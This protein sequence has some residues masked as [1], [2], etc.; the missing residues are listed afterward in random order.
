MRDWYPPG[1]H[2]TTDTNPAGEADLVRRLQAG[3]DDAYEELVRAYAGRL[4]GAVRRYLP[5]EDDARDAVQEAFLSAFKAIDRFEGGSRL[6]TWLY[7]IA[8]NAAL[9]Q[10]RRRSSR[11]SLHREKSTF[12]PTT[13]ANG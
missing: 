4:L 2:A 5:A 8:I 9:M 6:Y 1:M 7:R 12:R 3:D 11:R 10:I 13:R